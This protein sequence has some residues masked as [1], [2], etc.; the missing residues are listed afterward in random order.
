STDKH[1]DINQYLSQS[2]IRSIRSGFNDYLLKQSFQS[3]Q[4]G[5]TDVS[6]TVHPTVFTD[7]E[8]EPLAEIDSAN[9]GRMTEALNIADNYLFNE[10]FY[11]S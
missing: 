2:T 7:E 11:D 1:L 10:L 6:N 3:Y 8:G 9:L 5:L 4:I